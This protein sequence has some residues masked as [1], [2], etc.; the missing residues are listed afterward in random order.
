MTQYYAEQAQMAANTKKKMTFD[1]K[2]Y[3]NARLAPG[4]ETKTLTVRLLPY[5]LE[6]TS[7]FKK[8]FVHSIKVNKEI[9]PSGWKLFVCPT[10]NKLGDNCPFCTLSSEARRLRFET[11]DDFKKK[12][13]GDIEYANKV[14]EFWAVR[15]IERD[16][17]EDGPKVLVIL[18]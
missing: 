14:K 5:S 3:L 2:H 12:E 11:A 18:S 10:H 7:P 16:H 13:L 8:V 15:C 6:H 1:A 17:E 4:E 9:A